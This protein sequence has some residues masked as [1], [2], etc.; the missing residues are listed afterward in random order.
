MADAKVQIGLSGEFLEGTSVDTPAG[1]N[2]FR[3]GVVVSDPTDPQAR[4]NIRPL[5]VDLQQTDMGI[6]TH[7]VIQGFSTGGGGGFHDVKVTPSGALTVEATIQ[8]PLATTDSTDIEYLPVA[9][10][11]MALGDTVVYTPAAGKRVRLHWVY[12]I[13]DPYSLTSSKI[14]IRIGT[15]VLYVAWA[16]SKRQQFTGDINAPLVVNLSSAANVAFTAFVEEI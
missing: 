5:S 16:I 7:S 9:T 6:V 11:I 1:T 13:N 3:E 10:T 8:E 12:A 15:K 2:L 4:A 14:T